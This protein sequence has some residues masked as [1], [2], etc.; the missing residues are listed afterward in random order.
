M[1]FNEL[2]RTIARSLF[3]KASEYDRD[4]YNTNREHFADTTSIT[5]Q[6]LDIEQLRKQVQ[7]IN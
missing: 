3:D 1:K 6:Q 2:K 7:P 5:Y 4:T